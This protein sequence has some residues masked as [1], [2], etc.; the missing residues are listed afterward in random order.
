MSPSDIWA[1]KNR[2]M[3]R[4][5]MKKIIII[6]ASGLRVLLVNFDKFTLRNTK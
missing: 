3:S 5:G 1:A 2:I 4:Q 6:Y